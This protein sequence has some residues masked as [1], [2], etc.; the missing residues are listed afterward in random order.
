MARSLREQIDWRE[1][2]ARTEES[3]FA[4]TFFFLL[5]ELQIVTAEESSPHA[6]T[7]IRVVPAPATP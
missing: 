4:R 7:H 2:R 1:V 6:G 3:P 5:N